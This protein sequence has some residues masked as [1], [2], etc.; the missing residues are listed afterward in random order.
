MNS[1]VKRW[2]ERFLLSTGVAGAAQRRLPRSA[3]LV[4]AYHDVVTEGQDAVGDSSLHLSRR[5]FAEQLE[6]LGDTFD[7]VSLADAMNSTTTPGRPR[8]AITFDDAYD[9]TLGAA[10]EELAKRDLPGTIFV[11]PA[12]LGNT[13]WWDELA[14]PAGGGVPVVARDH[15][16][17]MLGG[18]NKQ[19]MA[20]ARDELANRGPRHTP[21]I[22]SVDQLDRAASMPRITLAAHTWSHVN[23]CAIP[24]AERALELS[25]PL[26]WLAERYEH[27]LPMMSYPYG[28]YSQAVA[29]AVRD[30][31]YERA[32]RVDGGWVR[33][34]ANVDPHAIPR[35][36]VPAGLSLDGFRLRLAGIGAS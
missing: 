5:R 3:V 19:V 34:P 4:L 16:L 36:N 22:G 18:R 20:W 1:R 32:F 24:P 9:G 14:N 28:L 7:I 30:A 26:S 6:L 2:A 11:A 13:A 31:G 29:G 15:A 27:T 12:L 8:V 17:W 25:R 35:Y 23:L 33:D 10:L 21:R